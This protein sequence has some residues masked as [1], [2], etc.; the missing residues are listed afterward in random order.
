MKYRAIRPFRFNKVVEV[1]EI[2]ELNA[3]E[4]DRF[5]SSIE[6]VEGSSFL[7]NKPHRKYNKG[8]KK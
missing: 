7:D 5:N 1:G 2:V 3:I 8:R 6:Y 4:A